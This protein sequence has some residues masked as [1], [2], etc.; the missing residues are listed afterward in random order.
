MAPGLIPLIAG[1]ILAAITYRVVNTTIF[2]VY[3]SQRFNHPL[4]A[5]L[6]HSIIL[7]WPSHLLAAPLAVVLVA[8]ASRTG[9]LWSGLALT[10]G[11]LI[12]LPVARQEYAYYI[13]SREMLD[14]TVEAVV[15]VLEGVDSRARAHGDRVSLLAVETGRHL[16]M[17]ERQ[18]VALRLASRL[19]DVGI[20]AE[21]EEESRGE[22]HAAIG[23]GAL[24]QFPEPL[25][26]QFVRAHHERWDG[27]GV[28]DHLRGETIP[29]GARILA[30]AETYDS[31]RAGL[32][33]FDAPQAPQDASGHLAALAGTA[34][35]PNVVDTV[36]KVAEQVDDSR[37]AG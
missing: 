16:R 3:R 9:T 18:L 15:R 30:A 35:D 19:H 22:H 36:L 8:V 7:Q 26:W 33:P 24:A 2:A 13:R 23:G 37:D 5:D 32:S 10:A 4:L 14:E 28:P 29:L 25:I 31:A 21:I 20:L 27:E 17:S 34:L 12:A 11:C 1:A 6:R